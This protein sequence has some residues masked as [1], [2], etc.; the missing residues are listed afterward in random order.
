[1]IHDVHVWVHIVDK[2]MMIEIWSNIDWWPH[3][4]SKKSN[5]HYHRAHLAQV[6]LWL[7]MPYVPRFSSLHSSGSACVHLAEYKWKE[8]GRWY[9]LHPPWHNMHRGPYPLEQTVAPSNN[10]ISGSVSATE[11]TLQPWSRSPCRNSVFFPRK[12]W[13]FWE[14]LGVIPSPNHETEKNWSSSFPLTHLYNGPTG[15]WIFLT[16]QQSQRKQSNQCRHL[17]WAFSAITKFSRTLKAVA[18]LCI[19]MPYACV[20]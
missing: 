6:K 18:I 20:L 5:A 2:K 17:A 19:R 13:K 12:S 15:V 3:A 14:S 9:V 7:Q 10:F 8:R 16:P 4:M 11:L 1:M